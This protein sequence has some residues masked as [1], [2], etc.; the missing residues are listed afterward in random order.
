MVCFKAKNKTKQKVNLFKVRVL[1]QIVFVACQYTHICCAIP[2]DLSE[3]GLL[4]FSQLYKRDR[5]QRESLALLLYRSSSDLWVTPILTVHFTTCLS[6]RYRGGN[7]GGYFCLNVSTCLKT[8]VLRELIAQV[9]KICSQQELKCGI[10]SLTTLPVSV[11]I[12]LS[13][14]L[15]SSLSSLD[16][17]DSRLEKKICWDK[18]LAECWPQCLCLSYHALWATPKAIFLH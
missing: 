17:R 4:P 6:L 13:S 9:P 11:G 15:L 5:G 1:Y 7:E 2:R 14:T 16:P 8:F 3:L 18:R 12:P 10:P